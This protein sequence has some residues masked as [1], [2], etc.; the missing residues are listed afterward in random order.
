MKN[1]K[2]NR[3]E[4]T[5]KKS[6]GIYKFDNGLTKYTLNFNKKISL[7]KIKNIEDLVNSDATNIFDIVDEIECLKLNGIHS[8]KYFNRN[9]DVSLLSIYEIIFT[10]ATDFEGAKLSAVSGYKDLNNKVLEKD[11]LKLYEYFDNEFWYKYVVEE[12]FKE[13]KLVLQIECEIL[14]EYENI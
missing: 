2:N 9:I 7:N 8:L 12:T 11:V 6:K 4:S 14:N 13:D 5:K 1:Q 10:H 3:K